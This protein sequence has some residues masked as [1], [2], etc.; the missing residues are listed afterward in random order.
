MTKDNLS[1][2]PEDV[3]G[4]DFDFYGKTKWPV[5]LLTIPQ[6]GKPFATETTPRQ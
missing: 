6:N 3:D 2:K 1:P 5:S 4:H